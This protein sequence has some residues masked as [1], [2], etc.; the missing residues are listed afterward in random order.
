ME[1][2]LL[3][4]FVPLNALS[5]PVLNELA[6]TAEE[7]NLDKGRVIFHQGDN[8][9]WL[10]F[11]LEGEVICQ[12][13]GHAPRMVQ[14][15]S[16]DARY[17]LAR[18]RPRSYSAVASTAVRLFR[19]DE[20]LLEARLGFDQATAYEVFEYDGSD[21]PA[22]ML[23]IL[24]EPAFRNVPPSQANAMFE[25]FQP[26]ACKAGDVIIQQGD[27][28]EHYYLIRTGRAQVSR[29]TPG[30]VPIV[31]AELGPGDGFGEEALLTGERR[32]ATVAMLS[33]G[34]LMRLSRQ[35]FDAL[36][37][38]PLVKNVDLHAARSMLKAGAQLVDVRLEEEFSAGTLRGSVN[39][40]LYLLRLKAGSLDP[41]KKYILFC[42]HDQRSSAAAFLLAQRGLDAYVLRGGLAALKPGEDDAHLNPLADRPPERVHPPWEHLLS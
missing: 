41:Q 33:D 32:S 15:G 16:D 12:E 7:V 35:D 24:A 20:T 1:S 31:L 2:N 4:Q 5:Q 11:L 23:K 29:A 28:A 19:I 39:L 8:D 30:G 25:R 42:Q 34:L 26:L 17:A 6:A 27:P 37:K 10:Y 3:S 36:L 14:S 21:D 13:R 18:T 38:R 9:P 40:P 22:W